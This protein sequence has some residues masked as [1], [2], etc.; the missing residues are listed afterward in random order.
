MMMLEVEQTPA[1]TTGSHPDEV[2]AVTA[3]LAIIFVVGI[4]YYT[5]T[6][7]TAS[8]EE[9]S[10]VELG[11]VTHASLIGSH[12][13]KPRRLR[14][15]LDAGNSTTSPRQGHNFNNVLL[16]GLTAPSRLPHGATERGVVSWRL[17]P[18]PGVCDY[19]VLD[20]E[21]SA[22][23]SYDAIFGT[24]FGQLPFQ[25]SAAQLR[26]SL[27]VR[28][29]GLLDGDRGT[30]GSA[31]T[32][33]AVRSTALLY[34]ELNAG[35]TAAG[36]EEKDISNF[37]ALRPVELRKNFSLFAKL[38]QA[39]DG[40]VRFIILLS[41][42]AP[43]SSCVVEATSAWDNTTGCFVRDGVQ[44]TVE[45][46]L[47]L[48][49]EVPTPKSQFALTLTLRMDVFVDVDYTHNAQGPGQEERCRQ[50]LPRPQAPLRRRRSVPS[51]RGS[52]ERVDVFWN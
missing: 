16:C 5:T 52:Q 25:N 30:S 42:S 27:G 1:A 14:M 8:V 40:L 44:P 47:Q 46:C 9:A 26:Q 10:I 15:T 23:G 37:F 49:T 7:A 11:G 43:R 33:I 45:E 50:E 4:V 12:V 34:A 2:I 18:E 3:V 29:F 24:Q 38:L 41:I 39:L 51:R 48:I 6:S 17:L 36:Y 31:V 22:D 13:A 35:L 32:E 28:G 19:F 20:I 21:P